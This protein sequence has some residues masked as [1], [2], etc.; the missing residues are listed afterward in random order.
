[1]IKTRRHHNN[2]GYRQ[3]KEGKTIDQVKK[4]AKK[5]GIPYG[6]DVKKMTKAKE[7][8]DDLLNQECFGY[9]PLSA[10]VDDDIL[11]DL[12]LDVGSVKTIREA[13]KLLDKVQRGGDF[14]I[15]MCD[16]C[17]VFDD[18]ISNNQACDLIIKEI[19]DKYI[20]IERD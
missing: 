9:R 12:F 17:K 10:R 8:L 15:A 18:T 19:T 1:M 3:I 20:L 11:L 14:L 2:K 4:I 13:L 7:A 16:V 5:L 6:K